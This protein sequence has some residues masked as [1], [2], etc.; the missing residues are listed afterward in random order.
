MQEQHVCRC[1]AV[2]N[3]TCRCSAGSGSG[4]AGSITESDGGIYILQ[5]VCG[6]KAGSRH[7]NAQVCVCV[8]LW[9]QCAGVCVCNACVK[10]WHGGR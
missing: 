10:R 9:G 8:G 1:G 2:Q 5:V 7:S 3:R 6:K 4:N